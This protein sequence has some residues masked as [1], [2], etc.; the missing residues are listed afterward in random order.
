MSLMAGPADLT[1]LTDL[2][3]P[4]G[5]ARPA[6]LTSLLAPLTVLPF[7]MYKFGMLSM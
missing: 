2:A 5:L 3:G 1:D 7:E 6:G 4:A